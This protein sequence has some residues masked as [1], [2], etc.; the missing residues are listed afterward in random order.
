MRR[1]RRGGANMEI[2]RAAPATADGEIH[3]VAAP[4]TVW[5]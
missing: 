1:P 5:T 3:I 4:E 2:N